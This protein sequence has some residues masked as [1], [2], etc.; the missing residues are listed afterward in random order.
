GGTRV[1]LAA[2]PAHVEAFGFVVGIEKRVFKDQDPVNVI[3]AELM[4]KLHDALKASGYGG[5]SLERL[6][7]RLL[8]CLFADDTGI[9]DELEL[10]QTWI[11]DRTAV[12]GYDLGHKRAKLFQVLN[13]P[14]EARQTN[15]GEALARFPYI[16]GGLFALPLPS[17]AF[18]KA[19]R[20]RLLEACRFSW[21]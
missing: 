20:E 18:D 10:F 16:S 17:P 13:T 1:G 14:V 2:L 15:L 4:G 11:E 8:F 6:L 5:A 9:Y 12:D 7:V 21:E 19:M 3:A